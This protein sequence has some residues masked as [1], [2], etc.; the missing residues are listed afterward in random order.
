[1]SGLRKLIGAGAVMAL[2]LA[3]CEINTPEC[4]K[5]CLDGFWMDSG[6]SPDPC[7]EDSDTTCLVSRRFP[8]PS[9]SELAHR[10]V[11]IAVHGYT[12]S[13]YEWQEFKGYAEDT[14]RGAD[15][16]VSLV[17]LGGHGRDLDAFQSSTWKDW[18]R[19]ILVEYDSLRK[20]GY[21]NV[22]FAC[23]S[24]G[25]A[26]LMEYLAAGAFADRAQPR[27]IF[28]IDPI[29]VPSAKLLS[30]AD[31]VGPILGNSPNPGSDEENRHW[32]VNRPEETLKQLYEL[33]NRV[34]N[35]LEDGFNLPAGTQAKVYKTKKDRSADP[36]GALIIWKGM[37]KS[38]GG[39]IEAELLDSRLHV[40][41][42]LQ[43]RDPAPS[44]ADSALQTR[45][46][47]EMTGKVLAGP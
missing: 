38:D 26:L 9:D 13:T 18:G 20:Q 11:I 19:P 43:G 24:T 41:T 36:V 31:L 23:S 17:L 42:R 46:F 39:H 34:K 30:L 3:A 25:C 28:M 45:V 12:A 7:S 22:S 4:D 47:G 2:C 8:A 6:K 5:E 21:K 27:W 15:V 16:R 35:R 29:V 14:A 10:Q 1:M 33:V 40:F 37:R 44:A 32:Y